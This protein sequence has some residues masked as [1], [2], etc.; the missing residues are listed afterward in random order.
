VLNIKWN[1]FLCSPGG[2][3]GRWGAPLIRGALGRAPLGVFALGKYAPLGR[4]G[5]RKVGADVFFFP[6]VRWKVFSQH[7][8]ELP[9]ELLSLPISNVAFVLCFPRLNKPFAFLN[10][11]HIPLTP[12]LKGEL[13][14]NTTPPNPPKGGKIG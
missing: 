1:A 12:L 7:Q 6:P 3:P 4:G 14:G 9:E 2:S 10:L 11:F 13:I 5:K 8:K